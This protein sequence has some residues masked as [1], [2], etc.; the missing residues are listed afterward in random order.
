M[1][2]SKP[3]YKSRTFWIAVLQILIGVLTAVNQ[4]LIIGSTITLLG[5]I[6][7]ILRTVT[8]TPVKFE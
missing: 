1:E 7:I 4:E 5:L 8:T 6:Q 2:T 3:I